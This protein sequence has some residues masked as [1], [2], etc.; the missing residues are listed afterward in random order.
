MQRILEDIRKPALLRNGFHEEN[1]NELFNS[2]GKSYKL[3]CKKGKG[4]YWIY[5][6]EN[7][8]SFAIHDFV[9][10]EDF[11]LECKMPEYISLTYYDSISGEE[12][13]PYKRLTAGCVKGYFSD[14]DGYQ[15]LIHKNIPVR[16][17]GIELM[18]DYY[19]KYLKE[20]YPGEYTNPHA[21]F[22]SIDETTQFPEMVLLLR[23]VKNYRGT[24]MAA[25]LFY[26]GK[27]AEAVSLILEKM[28][29]SQP[30]S[31]SRISHQ[32]IKQLETVVAH[33][34]D[35]FDLD[36]RLTQLSEI[37]CMGTTKLKSTFKEVHRC[38]ITE[39]IQHRRMGRAAHLLTN[40]DICIG[41]IAQLV[42]Y[43]S[44]SRFSELFRKN[45]GLLPFEYRNLSLGEN[46]W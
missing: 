6:H 2:E 39:Y 26:E 30:K 11:L 19:E 23:Q 42:G 4:H 21:A 22:L 40:T 31:Q 33:I 44:A 15:A 10:Y 34:N 18:P 1:N 9:F 36:L 38:T 43:R 29:G 25:K 3:D 12:L 28:K 5:T 17:I 8:F 41:Q 46:L 37:A 32:D 35:H 27:A 7:L 20:K 13:N 16:S 14:S 24:G 45:I